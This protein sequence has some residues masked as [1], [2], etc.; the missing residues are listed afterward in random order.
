MI[1]VISKSL[2]IGFNALPECAA[3][4]KFE[5]LTKKISNNLHLNDSI[6]P[7]YQSHIVVRSVAVVALI[8]G[9]VVMTIFSLQVPL[10]STMIQS[11]S[12]VHM[13]IGIASFALLAIGAG[14]VIHRVCHLEDKLIKAPGSFHGDSGWRSALLERSDHR[15]RALIDTST[16]ERG[17]GEAFVY[18]Y[19]SIDEHYNVSFVVTIVTPIHLLGSLAYSVARLAVVPLYIVGCLCI[20]K[21]KG[22]A[23]F[24]E[25]RA[26]TLWDIP[27]Q[28]KKTGLRILKA[29]FYA[30]A[31]IFASLYSFIDPLNGR[32][33]GAGIER[34]W[35]EGLSRA[36]GFGAATGAQP[37]F[38]PEGWG[39]PSDLGQNVVYLAA[40]WQPIAMA[41]YK[42]GLIERVVSLT[43][44]VN[45][46]KG[47][48]Y[49][50]YTHEDCRQ[51]H[52]AL[53]AQMLE[54]E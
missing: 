9:I 21:V 22:S 50:L 8:T 53:V 42:K 27:D 52:N 3:L 30:T 18:A 15:Y 31:L 16:L 33:L 35:N 34:D 48:E 32:K 40:C 24:S 51:K 26:F 25:D 29:P 28:M 23:L 39:S 12:W 46:S 6:N 5:D 19:K 1:A 54:S 14:F 13:G 43:R 38:K 36:E 10:L 2:P 20:E 37:L 49:T 47:R 7:D 17:D 41:S 11:I 45:P 4:S 44:A